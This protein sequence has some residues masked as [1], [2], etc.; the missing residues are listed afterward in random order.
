MKLSSD[1]QEQQYLL[2]LYDI[3]HKNTENKYVE[4]YFSCEE[5]LS[6]ELIH[7]LAKVE[8]RHET[9]VTMKFLKM[10]LKRYLFYHIR[11]EYE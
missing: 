7:E 3:L 1:Q 8:A 9:E 11:F 2:N 4:E 10:F 5:L 6:R